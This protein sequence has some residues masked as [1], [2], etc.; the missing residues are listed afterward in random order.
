MA[1][2]QHTTL[3]TSVLSTRRNCSTCIEWTSC[4]STT[5][6]PS[7]SRLDEGGEQRT[8]IS[9]LDGWC[10]SF[11]F[12]SD[13]LLVMDHLALC[14]CH[15]LLY[16]YHPCCEWS[17]TNADPPPKRKKNLIFWF[18]WV[19]LWKWKHISSERSLYWNPSICH[20]CQFAFQC[21]NAKLFWGLAEQCRCRLLKTAGDTWAVFTHRSFL[22]GL[23]RIQLFIFLFTWI[24]FLIYKQLCQSLLIIL[25]V[26]LSV[27]CGC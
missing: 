18:Q 13:F 21:E 19:E 14:G 2:W 27:T 8:D 3:S 22:S 20:I 5:P 6:H 1:T 26:S 25:S 11:T 10:F 23:V 15:G 12:P 24:P 7:T 4:S 9:T 16:N 17:I